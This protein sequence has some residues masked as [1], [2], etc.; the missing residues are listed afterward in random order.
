MTT[1]SSGY[2]VSLF[3]RSGSSN[4]TCIHTIETFFRGEGVTLLFVCVCSV[5]WT[6]RHALGV[7]RRRSYRP[8]ARNRGG[9]GRE[10]RLLKFF[11]FFLWRYA[12]KPTHFFNCFNSRFRVLLLLLHSLTICNRREFCCCRCRRPSL[13]KTVIG[14]H[15]T[16]YLFFLLFYRKRPVRHKWWSDCLRF[17]RRLAKCFASASRQR[18][19]PTF[20][21]VM[22]TNWN[23]NC[24]HQ[25]IAV[26]GRSAISPGSDS[27]R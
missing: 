12:D 20:W 26:V 8:R 1:L 25:S 24:C 27:T 17:R 18:L 2:M 22:Q 4:N 21:T 14:L 9:G 6:V 10:L 23:W 11:C 13:Y 15:A 5:H 16:H 3:S 7:P 19:F